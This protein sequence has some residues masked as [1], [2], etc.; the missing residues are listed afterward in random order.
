VS[1]ASAPPPWV[2]AAQAAAILNRSSV[3]STNDSDSRCF[4]EELGQRKVL[5]AVPR[6]SSDDDTA[7]ST[8]SA[9]SGAV[10]R[11]HSHL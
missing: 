2:E 1:T 6:R 3:S 7:G 9:P 11:N 8:A 5:G 4:G 10:A